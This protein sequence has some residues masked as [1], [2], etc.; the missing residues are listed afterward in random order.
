[1]PVLSTTATIVS[2]DGAYPIAIA[3]GTLDA[4]NYDFS[5]V[6]GTLSVVEPRDH[7]QPDDPADA[8]VGATA[9]SSRPPAARARLCLLVRQPA[10]R[11]HAQCER[12]AE[13]DADDEFR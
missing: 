5:T 10:S 12:P 2:P 9:S 3:I 6:G 13:R 11:P 1:M 7:A 8:T 4:A